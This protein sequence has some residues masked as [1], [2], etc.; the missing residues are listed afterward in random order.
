MG[1]E[2]ADLDRQR[3]GQGLRD[4]DGVAHL[5]LA[6]PALLMH[7][8]PLHLAAQGHRPAE[9]QRA[10]AQEIDPDLNEIQTEALDGDSEALLGSALSMPILQTREHGKWSRSWTG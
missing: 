10:K 9:P 3:P 7:Q 1:D 2:N 5:V 8:L 4:S 6:Q